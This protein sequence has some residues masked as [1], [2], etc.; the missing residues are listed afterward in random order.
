MTRLNIC[1]FGAVRT[2][3][4]A[5]LLAIGLV[6]GTA[7]PARADKA[8][9]DFALTANYKPPTFTGFL[10]RGETWDPHPLCNLC[11]TYGGPHYVVNDPLG[12][13]YDS[14]SISVVS[15]NDFQGTVT[16][17]ILNLPPGVTSQ[18]ATSVLLP[19]RSAASTAFKLTA[20]TNAT[21]G[22]ATVTVQATSGALVHT[23]DLPISVGDQLPP[24]Q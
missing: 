24:C 3:L 18:T 16:L 5:G 1:R 11:V 14:N 6:L 8:A 4:L 15:L 13:F 7:T 17:A 20:A 12:C 2:L 22:S 9:P 19:R 10:I 23:I 21:V